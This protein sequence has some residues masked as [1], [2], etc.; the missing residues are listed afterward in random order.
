MRRFTH[1]RET[2]QRTGSKSGG[3]VTLLGLPS[4]FR[5]AVVALGA[6]I[7]V[8]V[9]ERVSTIRGRYGNNTG[10][11]VRVWA[12]K[13]LLWIWFGSEVWLGFW[14]GLD[15]Y[16]GSVKR[17]TSLLPRWPFVLTFEPDNMC[18]IRAWEGEFISVPWVVKTMGRS[19][20]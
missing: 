8:R 5:H 6:G 7:D 18:S 20:F 17:E 3:K 19:L 10:I 14:L 1:F 15:H 4:H 12:V 2:V 16:S 11:D 13:S 9:W